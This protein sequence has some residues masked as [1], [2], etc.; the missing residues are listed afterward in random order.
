M[1]IQTQNLRAVIWPLLNP[2]TGLLYCDS[3]SWAELEPERGAVDFDAVAGA[4]ERAKSIK[5]FALL[6]VLPEAPGWCADPVGDYIRL[7]G[8][9]GERFGEERAILG[10]DALCPDEEKRSEAELAAIARAYSQAFPHARFYV[11]AGSALERAMPRTAKMGLIV[12]RDNVTDHAERWK[13][14]PLRMAVDP[15]NAKEIAAAIG[16]RVSILEAKSRQGANAATHAGYRFEVRSVTLD[17]TRRHE[18]WVDV[19]VAIANAGDLPCY[20]DAGFRVRL[21]GSDVSD[22]REYP[23]P[24]RALEVMPGE[25]VELSRALDVKGL[26]SGEYDVHI[27]LFFDGTAYPASF[28]IEGRISDGYYEGRLILRVS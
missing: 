10:V 17:D 9:L 7:I 19:R 2:D 8:A 28:G 5:R 13:E 12:T 6:R 27:G 23:L 24:L 25:C 4:I 22:V 11:R 14:L 16:A 15:A 26:A 20:T 1:G 18:G 21:C 3:F